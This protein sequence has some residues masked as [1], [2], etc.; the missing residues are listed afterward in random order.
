MNPILKSNW[1][2]G[3]VLEHKK[4]T[5]SL[6]SI[7][8][9]A[10]VN[11]YTSGQFTRIG[12]EINNEIISRPYSYVSS[13]CDNYLEIIYVKIPEGKLTPKL[14]KL[15]NGDKLLVNNN[16][17]GFFIMDEVPKGDNLWML[18]T[19]TGLGVFISILKT[20]DPWAKFNKIVLIHGVRKKNELAYQDQISK[21]QE[22]YPNQLIY[23]KSVTREKINEILNVRLP[24]GIN[25]GLFESIANIKISKKSQFML[26]GNPNMI[27]DSISSLKSKGIEINRKSAPG[28]IT[29]EKYW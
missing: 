8:I 9:D 6:A 24:N 15:K 16:A 29:L 12:L 7:K 1:I 4:W 22:K 10:K 3:K 13:P 25:S 5:D 11:P 20:K 26:C 14:S 21:F 28:N 2:E 27:K 23:I 17:Y 19:G 18:A